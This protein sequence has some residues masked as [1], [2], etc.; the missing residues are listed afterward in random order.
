MP[1]RFL[2]R[3]FEALTLGGISRGVSPLPRLRRGLERL[4]DAVLSVSIDSAIDLLLHECAST[5]PAL[6]TKS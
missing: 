3:S 6:Q 2:R 4:S 1:G 5:V